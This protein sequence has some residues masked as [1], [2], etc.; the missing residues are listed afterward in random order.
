[1]LVG[2][3]ADEEAC[4]RLVLD[5]GSVDGIVLNVGIGRGG[6]WRTRVPRTGT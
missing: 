1:M 6:G 5:A 2:D 3:V 4:A